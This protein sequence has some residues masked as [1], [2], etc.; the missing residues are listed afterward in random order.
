MQKQPTKFKIVSNKKKAK[1]SD[2]KLSTKKPQDS[3]DV[4]S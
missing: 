2:A 1:L 3:V 4:T